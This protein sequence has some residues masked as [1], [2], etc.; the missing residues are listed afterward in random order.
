MGPMRK[1]TAAASALLLFAEFFSSPRAAAADE[2]PTIIERIQKK[3]AENEEMRKLGTTQPEALK[4]ISWM[5]GDWDAVVRTHA[6]KIEGEKVEKGTRTTR[7]E[8][9]GRWV[10]SRNKGAGPV[11]EDAVELLGF[12]PYQRL[13]RWQFFSSVGRGTNAALTSNQGWDDNRLTFNG[14]FWVWGDSADVSMRIVK[15]SNDEYYEIFEEKIPGNV[16]RPFL[17]YHYKRA[18]AAPAAKPPAK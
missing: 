9:A 4:A 16:N 6:T 18:K 5:M 15:M 10:V 13:W 2:P 12:D 3:W 1:Q 14:T 8:L 7:Y 11:G 17:E